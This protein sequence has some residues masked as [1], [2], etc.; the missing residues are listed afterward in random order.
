MVRRAHRPRRQPALTCT[1][2]LRFCAGH[3]IVGH[4]SKCR[5]LHGHEY[6]V[7]VTARAPRL[8]RVGRV[9]DFGVLKE[10][11]GGWIDA[12]WDHRLILFRNDRVFRAALEDH[13]PVFVLPVNPTA[14]NLAH[15]LLTV[16]CPKVLRGTGVKVERIELW[17][18]ENGRAEAMW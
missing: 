18:T 14:E 3:R 8:D 16:V 11:V 15:Y 2:R 9:I 7:R 10:R 13:T 5:W 1:R 6:E 4:E 12:H 17:E